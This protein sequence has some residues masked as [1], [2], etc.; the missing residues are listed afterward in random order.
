[1]DTGPHTFAGI[2]IAFVC[3]LL[4]LG[5]TWEYS[6]EGAVVVLT[7]IVLVQIMGAS[8]L[9]VGFGRDL[10]LYWTPLF[11]L[12]YS[13]LSA[14]FAGILFAMAGSSITSAQG[15]VQLRTSRGLRVNE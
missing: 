9:F 2:V 11:L 10:R 5:F 3:W 6:L 14:G 8:A 7:A 1:M 13:V 12:G 15:P 4:S